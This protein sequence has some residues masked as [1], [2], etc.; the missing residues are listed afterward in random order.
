MPQG[1]APGS[2]PSSPGAAGVS[3]RR[4]C[5]SAWSN[6]SSA[7]DSRVGAGEP[8]DERRR[9]V[10]V[11][12]VGHAG[13]GAPERVACRD[14]DGIRDA[15]HIAAAS[16]MR[17][18]RSSS[19]TSVASACSAG[20]PTRAGGARPRRSRRLDGRRRSRRRSRRRPSPRRREQVLEPG[21]RGVL[22]FATSAGGAR[23]SRGRGAALRGWRGRS[24]RRA[25]RAVGV[26]VD[27]AREVGDREMTCSR[28]QRACR[29]SRACASSRMAR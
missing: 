22:R 13:R 20:P 1:Q 4:S 2:S 9:V 11:L 3:P 21:E 19:P 27:A 16:R 5:S 23:R 14:A 8:R 12:G 7:S 25:P 15:R 24:A 29:N 28:S 6:S 18:G 26:D 10:D 17:R